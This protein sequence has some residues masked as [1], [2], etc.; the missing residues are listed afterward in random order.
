MKSKIHE[1]NLTK[2]Y[3]SMT[4]NIIALIFGLLFI[5]AINAQ[6]TAPVVTKVN[7]TKSVTETK[8]PA[9]VVHSAVYN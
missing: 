7:T 4:K 2:K 5:V 8:T 3:T 6:E 9:P 1:F